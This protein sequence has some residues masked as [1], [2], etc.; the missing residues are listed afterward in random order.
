MKTAGCICSVCNYLEISAVLR[1]SDT[2][3]VAQYH[4]NTYPLLD[5]GACFH[6]AIMADCLRFAC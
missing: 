5:S 2:Q 6:T 3:D 4:G 1:S